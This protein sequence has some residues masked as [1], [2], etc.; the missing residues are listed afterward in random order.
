MDTVEILQLA[1][2]NL[3]NPAAALTAT[4]IAL[5]ESGGSATATNTKNTDG[6]IDTGL[7]Q[8]NSIHKRDHPTW[9]VPWLQNPSNNAKAMAIVSSNGSN[10][11]PWVKYKNGDYKKYI[12]Q[13][14]LAAFKIETGGS[15]PFDTGIDDVPVVGDIVE[16]AEGI[17]DAAG[18]IATIIG[19][20]VNKTGAWISKSENMTRIAQVVG[21]IVL[22]LIGAAIVA[23]SK[24]AR[25]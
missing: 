25:G 10:W 19:D 6:S 20:T 17:V 3:S 14:K 11:S 12:D 21:G 24:V 18:D 4:A 1:R 9:T 23:N 22:A 2:K 13:V 8:I 15:G 16:G 7:W 5:A